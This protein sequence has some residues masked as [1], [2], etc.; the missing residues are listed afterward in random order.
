VTTNT[1]RRVP[2]DRVH[3]TIQKRLIGD[4]LPIVFDLRESHGSWIVDARTGEE[5]LDFFS[6][7]ASLPLGFHH[8]AFHTPENAERLFQAAIHKPSNSDAH[9]AELASFT[10][11]FGRVAA[12]E[13]LPHLF[14]VEGGT[15]AVENGL[16]TAFDWKVRKNLAAGKDPRGTRVIH[17]RQAFHGRS[18]YCLSLTNTNPVKTD[19]F[20]K[21]DWPRITN[22]RLRFPLGPA[23]AAR[24]AREEES[25]IREIEAA[26]RASP[27]DIAA[28]IIETIQGEGGDNHFRKEFLAA[29]RAI[30]DR[31]EAL[32]IFD[33]VQCGFGITG[34]FWAFEHFSVVPDIVCF[35]KKSQVCG[36]LAGPRID[37]VKDNVFRLSS[38]INSTWGGN[39]TD[40]VRCEIIL[41]TIAS[42]RL[43][44]NA[45]EV[46]EHL[47]D[48]L[49]DLGRRFP[50]FVSNVRGRGLMCA[51]DCPGPAERDAVIARA[52]EK[53]LVIL[54]CGELSVRLRPALNVSRDEVDEAAN[55]LA[56]AIRAAR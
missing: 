14:F 39:L 42:E 30:A 43:V 52:R 21:F 34:R 10:E 3:Q 4:G 35:G 38:R 41:E 25:A 28:I 23:E 15:L 2:P 31:E 29:L 44:E 1:T 48:C 54:P 27:G 17:F 9:T 36:I 56:D 11:T 49:Q 33:E 22:P 16:K 12:R 37:Q 50:E 51:F 40:M 55:R 32:L 8:P 7:F 13:A 6:F 45:A 5:Y 47:L 26:F 53:H 24:V 46:G 18:G 19:Y 20:P